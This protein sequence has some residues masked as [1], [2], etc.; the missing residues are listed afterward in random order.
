[1]CGFTGSNYPQLE[2]LHEKY[3]SKGLSVL[4]FPSNQFGGQVIIDLKIYIYIL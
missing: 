3:S 1:M 2:E 4:A